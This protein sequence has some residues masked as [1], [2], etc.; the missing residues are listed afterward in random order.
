[1]FIYW[2]VYSVLGRG[3]WVMENREIPLGA[4]EWLASTFKAVTFD[5]R[6]WLALPKAAG[7]RYFTITARQHDGFSILR[8]G[9]TPYNVVDWTPFKRNPWQELVEECH[10]QGVRLFFD[11]S[12]FDRHYPDYWPRGQTG[13]ATRPLDSGGRKRYLD[14]MG[15]RLEELLTR[16]GAWSTAIR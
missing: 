1:M 10:K 7:M 13:R 15:R 12:Q 9:A 2:G 14:F 16:T 6:E 11:Y 3:E 8:N 4:Y 5:A